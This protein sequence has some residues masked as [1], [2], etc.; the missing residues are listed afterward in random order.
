MS[1]I[2]AF[3]RTE[4]ARHNR[5][6][7]IVC[8]ITLCAAVAAWFFAYAIFAWLSILFASIARGLDATMPRHLPVIVLYGAGVLLLIALTMRA[9]PQ[10]ERPVDHRSFLQIIMDILLALPRLTIA[11]WTNLAAWQRL[12]DAE[13]G[14]AAQLL[15]YLRD[16]SLLP[17]QQL[18][19]IIPEKRA[20]RRIVLALQLAQLIEVKRRNGIT[21]LAIRTPV[22]RRLARSSS[23]R[24]RGREENR[25]TRPDAQPSRQRA[26]PPRVPRA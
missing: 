24:T 16:A 26:Q 10:D 14:Q 8:I 11:M 5:R 23:I 15:E 20:C 1:G 6:V 7:A 19:L 13:V 25:L 21:A 3:V 9:F 22:R 18:P 12:S 4:I 2:E 17:V